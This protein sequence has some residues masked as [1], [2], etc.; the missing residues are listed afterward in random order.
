MQTYENAHRIL[1]R[2]GY[3]A[4]LPLQEKAFQDPALY[5]PQKNIFI[6]GDTS[7]GKTLI[8]LI[9]YLLE[10]DKNPD[11]KMLFLVPYRALA[12]Q[13][14]TEIAE[15]LHRIKPALHVALST[16]E[17]REEDAGIYAGN[18]DVAVIIYEKAYHFACNND[19]FLQRYNT[20]VYD[21]F[22]LS[23]DDSRGVTCDL[24]LLRGQS[25]NLRLFV[26]STPHYSWGHYI[27]N[28]NFVAIQLTGLGNVVPREELPI[29]LDCESKSGRTFSFHTFD[30]DPIEISGVRPQGSK[31]DLIED[32]CV[33]HLEQGH[34]ILVFMNNCSEVRHLAQKLAQRL[35]KSYSNLLN[36]DCRD[37]TACFQQMLDETGLLAED[38]FD[39]MTPDECRS[40]MQGICYHN[41]DIGYTLRSMIEREILTDAGLLKVVF[42]TET[43]AFGINSS[44]D[45]VIV[46]DMHK[47]ISRR[48]Y[49]PEPGE[50]GKMY[51]H[52]QSKMCNRFL[53]ANEYQNYIGRAGRYGRA[54][55][56]Y[57][58]ALMTQIPGRR[59]IRKQWAN[60]IKQRDNPPAANSTLLQLDPYCN[61]KNG[62]NYCPDNC[63]NCSLRADEFAMPVMSLITAKGVSYRQIKRQ[64][65]RLPGLAQDNKWLDRNINTALTRLIRD[66][67]PTPRDHGWVRC[68]KNKLTG[69]TLYYLTNAGQR[70]SGFMITM[71]EAKMMTLYLLGKNNYMSGNR[72]YTPEDLKRLIKLDP[73]DLFFQLCG[74]PELQKIAFEFFAITDVN[75]DAGIYRRDLYQELCTKQLC[76]YRKKAIS[77]ELYNYLMYLPTNTYNYRRNLPTLYRTLLTILVY[78][79]YKNASV[80]RLNDEL[81]VDSN[82]FVITPG[83]ISRMSQQVSFYL[84]VTE[85][86]CLTFSNKVYEEIAQIL[87]HMELCL[88]FGIREADASQIDVTHLRRLNRQQQ[89]KVTQILDFCGKHPSFSTPGQL[90]R[91]QCS[92][93]KK[94]LHNLNS[95][96]EDSEIPQQLREIYPILNLAETLLFKE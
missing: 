71:Y 33:K 9:H 69:E 35:R 51:I 73:F 66:T 13:K 31:D 61:Q 72:T 95:L 58:Y 60:L 94:I 78:E 36:P 82:Y 47:S 28:N 24:M 46:A 12:S 39:L 44:V 77:S 18:V 65:M 68:K 7:S 89:L 70:M 85:S 62:C 59:S 49:I 22:A 81:N 54:E 41:S 67:R 84:Q 37:E 29:F 40:F 75:N 17:C 88:Y 21:E 42:C 25:E 92:D 56:G 32:L 87:N 79:W 5:D 19:L 11:Y 80:G 8:P 16:G 55:K 93:W 38:L 3:P 91:R 74:L 48:N 50:D 53:T 2:M 20:L 57:A 86:L 23:E 83:R 34:R 4:F 26:L 43:M 52:G 30:G 45:V 27:H 10:K 14:Q 96:P 76:I 6:T 15:L 63:G 90:T 1:E 64:L